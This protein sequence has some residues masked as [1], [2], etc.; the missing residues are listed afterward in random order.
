[1]VTSSSPHQQKKK[2]QKDQKKNQTSN[3]LHLMTIGKDPQF[4]QIQTKVKRYLNY[5]P[6]YQFG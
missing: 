5:R 2:I 6:Q 1:M 4:D 3:L